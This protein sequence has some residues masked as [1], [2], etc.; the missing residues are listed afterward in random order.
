[1]MGLRRLPSRILKTRNSWRQ[2]HQD[3]VDGG[4][5]DMGELGEVLPRYQ[6]PVMAAPPNIVDQVQEELEPETERRDP[7]LGLLNIR[8]PSICL[9]SRLHLTGQSQASTFDRP[10]TPSVPGS[11][12]Q[13][14]APSG[15]SDIVEG[16]ITPG[17]N[18]GSITWESGY[19]GSRGGAGSMHINDKSHIPTQR[20][21]TAP[22]PPN[23][24]SF[25]S[26]TPS[27]APLPPSK[28]QSFLPM[29]S[30]PDPSLNPPSQLYK[31]R[32]STSF[33]LFQL[34]IL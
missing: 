8:M 34:F 18:Q 10:R 22:S 16:N 11:P 32:S 14:P 15:D 17:W 25:P 2:L 29:Q 5:F 33:T 3:E 4:L 31:L 1:M 23:G 6:S 21:S 12:H 24:R 20:Q 7:W 9:R 19:A 28:P 27:Q 30:K 26:R 13:I